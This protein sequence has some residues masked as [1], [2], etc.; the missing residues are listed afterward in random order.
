M[1]IPTKVRVACAFYKLAQGCNFL[2]CNELFDVGQ[3]TISL[4]LRKVITTSNVVFKNLIS[5]PSGNKMEMV[6][7]SFKTLCG[8][9]NIRGAID[10]THFSISKLDGDFCEY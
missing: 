3:S 2:I 5:W 4:V 6:M 8:L 9:P 10:G 1:S 7:H